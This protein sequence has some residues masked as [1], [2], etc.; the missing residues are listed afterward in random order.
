M[1]VFKKVYIS[2]F[3]IMQ[4]AIFDIN[5]SLYYDA[6]KKNLLQKQL[7]SDKKA[8]P[9]I[10]GPLKRDLQEEASEKCNTMHGLIRIVLTLHIEKNN[11]LRHTQIPLFK[12]LPALNSITVDEVADYM[13][14]YRESNKE[15]SFN[16]ID[17]IKVCVSKIVELRVKKLERRKYYCACQLSFWQ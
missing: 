17:L 8:F 4:S 14:R 13:R 6:P 10:L 11:I 2:L 1:A 7:D 9:V 12:I 5:K 3:A 15:L 16:N